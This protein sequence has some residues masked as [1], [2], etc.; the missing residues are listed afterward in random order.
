MGRQFDSTAARSHNGFV[1]LC[2]SYCFSYAKELLYVMLE[3]TL[4]K[5]NSCNHTIVLSPLKFTG[6]M[7]HCT[8]AH[9]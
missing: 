9:P 2:H 1:I 4:G 7:I 3:M 6:K 8:R 5:R